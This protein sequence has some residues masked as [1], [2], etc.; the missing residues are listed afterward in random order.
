LAVILFPLP[1]A[2]REESK[3]CYR[4]ANL[5]RGNKH[6]GLVGRRKN[7]TRG[8]PAKAVA[9]LIR[10][11]SA[12]PHNARTDEWL[13]VEC[14]VYSSLSFGARP[15]ILRVIIGARQKLNRRAE[16]RA[17]SA[18]FAFTFCLDYDDRSDNQL[19]LVGQRYR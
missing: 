7:R 16:N 2:R 6:A 18:P 17:A 9:G 1:P 19:F 4:A 8:K 5:K 13:A 11:L 12:P 10:Q 15:R 14:L 3:I